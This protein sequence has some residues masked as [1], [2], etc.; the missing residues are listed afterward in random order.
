MNICTYVSAISMQPKLYAVAV[1]YG[2][3]TLELA[4]QTHEAVLQLLGSEQ[5]RL[6]KTLGQRSGHA[7]DK[8]QLLSKRSLLTEF[9]GF[10]VLK[11]CCA[12]MLLRKMQTVDNDGDHALYIYRVEK[13]KSIHE[14]YLTTGLLRDKGIIRA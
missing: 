3:R 8:M 2:T 11:D 7:I 6:V 10:P 4:S 13:S 12:T 9:E 5:Y 1:Y 14:R